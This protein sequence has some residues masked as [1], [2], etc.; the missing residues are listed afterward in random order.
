MRD[1]EYVI[2]GRPIPLDPILRRKPNKN[3]WG[4]DPYSDPQ[5]HDREKTIQIL[6]M[7]HYLQ[8]F[9]EGPLKLSI[10]YY[11]NRG[12]DEQ[13]CLQPIKKIKMNQL[14]DFTIYCATGVIFE[15][16]E[17]II[18]ITSRKIFDEN[19]RTVFTITPLSPTLN[20][21]EDQT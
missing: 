5:L 20:L 9:L 18:E 21:M 1:P 8:S 16:E 13:K 15:R 19:P 2:E 7:Q 12:R 3:R 6:S 10:T 14:I 17:Q 11:M 4:S